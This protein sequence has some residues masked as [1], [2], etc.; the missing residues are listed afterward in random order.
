MRGANEGSRAEARNWSPQVKPEERR[1]F[2][3]LTLGEPVSARLDGQDV[4]LLEIG[5]LGARIRHGFPILGK[6]TGLLSFPW[7]G[8]SIELDCVVVRTSPAAADGQQ[9]SGLQF[10][11]ARG[12][13]DELLR[14]MLS[15]KVRPVLE[16][17]RSDPGSIP[18][19][20]IDADV[21]IRPRD[22]GYFCYRLESGQ[23]QKTRAFLPEQPAVGFTVAKHENAREIERLCRAYQNADAEGRRLIRLFA[24]LSVSEA[25]HLP[26]RE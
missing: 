9:Q 20:D 12:V 15:E 18:I 26:P 21:T 10:S 17:R 6:M 7:R 8:K 16:A 24:E 13:S 22:A 4:K 3:R 19:H 25:M 14:D 11:R 1:E 2:Q 5:I 23:W